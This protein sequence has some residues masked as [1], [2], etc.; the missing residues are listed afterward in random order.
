[1]EDGNKVEEAEWQKKRNMSEKKTTI[2]FRFKQKNE[3]LHT[4]CKI[5]F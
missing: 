2:H 4:V 1:M 5:S 3:I